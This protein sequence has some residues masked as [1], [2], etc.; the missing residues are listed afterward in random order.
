M[1]SLP[2]TRVLH[3]CVANPD[4][5]RGLDMRNLQSFEAFCGR[6]VTGEGSLRLQRAFKALGPLRRG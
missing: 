1:A 2:D 5:A 4:F 3:Y 6:T